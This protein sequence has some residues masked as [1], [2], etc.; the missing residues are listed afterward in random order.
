MKKKREE[1][2]DVAPLPPRHG[3]TAYWR[4][5]GPAHSVFSAQALGKLY[6]PKLSRRSDGCASGPMLAEGEERAI[7]AGH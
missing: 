2:K 1:L 4:Q 6:T 7:W 3:E 5:L